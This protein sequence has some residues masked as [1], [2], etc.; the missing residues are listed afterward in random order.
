MYKRAISLIILLCIYAM[1]WGA[2]TDNCISIIG[3]NHE[4]N[5]IE[6]NT[7]KF[8]TLLKANLLNIDTTFPIVPKKRYVF[9]SHDKA[10]KAIKLDLFGLTRGYTQIV[11]EVSTPRNKGYEFSLGLIGVGVN[12]TLKYFNDTITH[13]EGTNTKQ[14]GLFLSAG[15]KINKLPLF[16]LGRKR[17]QHYMQGAYAR[18]TFYLGAYKENRVVYMGNRNRRGVF[19]LERPLTKFAAVQIEFGK[20]WIYKKQYAFDLYWGL[21]YSIDNKY[22]YSGSYYNTKTTS[23]F[24]YVNDRLGSSPGLSFT[25]GFKTGLLLAK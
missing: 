16:Q 13:F 22:Y 25:F 7:S 18:P 23:A 6:S 12:K 1:S 14:R 8:N 24:N 11:Y 20:Q 19:D 10:R 9:N 4:R 21:G 2:S 5:S 17:R 15:Y 3:G